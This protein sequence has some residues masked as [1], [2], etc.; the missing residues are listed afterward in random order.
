M[1]TVRQRC[2][3]FCLTTAVTTRPADDGLPVI[4]TESVEETNIVLFVD[5]AVPL[6]L[7]D[8]QTS[9][10]LIQWSTTHLETADSNGLF[11]SSNVLPT[12]A[13]LF[14]RIQGP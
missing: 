7:F 9:S 13:F 5:T 1:R 6:G 14:Y 11:Q 2:A 4:R 3:W 12:N 10:N 8:V